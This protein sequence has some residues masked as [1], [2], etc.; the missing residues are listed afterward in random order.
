VSVLV[1]IVPSTQLPFAEILPAVVIDP[2][3]LSSSYVT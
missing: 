2:C 1:L 3:V